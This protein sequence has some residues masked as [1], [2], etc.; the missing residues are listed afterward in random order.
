MMCRSVVRVV[1]CGGV[2]WWCGSSGVV[3][4]WW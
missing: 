2:A 1:A 3:E 4:E